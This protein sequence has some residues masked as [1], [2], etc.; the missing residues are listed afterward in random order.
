MTP[1]TYLLIPVPTGEPKILTGVL[2]TITKSYVKG[3]NRLLAVESGVFTASAQEYD[4][5]GWVTIVS[6][7][8]T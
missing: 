1:Y 8:V 6:E 3:Q 7:P 5:A 2:A 4:G